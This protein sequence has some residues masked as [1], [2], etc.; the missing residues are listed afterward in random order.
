MDGCADG[1]MD[2]QSE[3]ILPCHYHVQSKKGMAFRSS[4]VQILKYGAK[5]M[6]S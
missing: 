1:H 5:N 3:N 2:V 4:G 6:F